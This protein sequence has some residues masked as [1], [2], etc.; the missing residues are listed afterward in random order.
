MS[1]NSD[2]IKKNN[3]IVNDLPEN[4][5][6]VQDIQKIKKRR[7]KVIRSCLFCRQR[8]LKCDHNYPKCSSCATRNIENCVYL[9]N[10]T[11]NTPSN[12]VEKNTAITTID[13]KMSIL[14]GKQNSSID[15]LTDD[16]NLMNEYDVYSITGAHG[17]SNKNVLLNPLQNYG[18]LFSKENKDV[19]LGP[20]SLKAGL[21][22][23]DIKFNTKQQKLWNIFEKER[24]QWKEANLRLIKKEMK[25]VER[26]Q[27]GS[28]LLEMCS[29]LPKYSE[30]E[31]CVREYFNSCYHSFFHI[32]D[33]RKVLKD[34]ESCI[35]HDEN[36]TVIE[37][38]LL[39]ERNYFSLAIVLYL[40]LFMHFQREAPDAMLQFFLALEAMSSGPLCFI[41]RAQFLMLRFLFKIFNEPYIHYLYVSSLVESLCSIIVVLGL[42]RD[43]RKI[44][45][46]KESK[47]GDIATLENLWYWTLYADYITS[48][49]LGKPLY[50]SDA[51][52]MPSDLKTF[53][54]GRLPLLKRFLY[55]S[56]KILNDLL[57]PTGIPALKVHL[58]II[59]KFMKKEFKR[60]RFYTDAKLV[61]QADL[62]EYL[63]LLPLMALR[64]CIGHFFKLLFGTSNTWNE[65]ELIRCSFN[66]LKMC[67]TLLTEAGSKEKVLSSQRSEF[68]FAKPLLNIAWAIRKCTVIRCYKDFFNNL[69]N[70]DGVFENCTK[71]SGKNN[72]L[73][74]LINSLD[75]FNA[76]ICY[77][78][79]NYIVAFQK[80]CEY[81]DE[82]Y[83]AE[84]KTISMSTN[85]TLQ[86]IQLKVIEKLSRSLLSE[87]ITE[88]TNFEASDQINTTSNETDD[89]VSNITGSL[90]AHS[91]E[92]TDSSPQHFQNN[93]NDQT[94]NDKQYLFSTNSDF[95]TLENLL[96]EDETGMFDILDLDLKQFLS[97]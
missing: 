31:T 32:L 71:D 82:Y 14:S 75:S 40:V 77:K 29:V 78:R 70:T 84:N 52:F 12:A 47:I 62:F 35:I 97:M 4:N 94:I 22:F 53:E 63:V 64:L 51:H 90:S 42:N 72:L 9:S 20:T 38:K 10:G 61:K 74:Q 92:I 80:Y 23:S 69:Y 3:I 46:G 15:N 60:I 56:R 6:N 26:S 65:N 55:I 83:D 96:G 8:K 7:R 50:F 79:S 76:K 89:S 95:L 21:V 33:E 2:S 36:D 34:M 5:D 85:T 48:F 11:N 68:I 19:Y 87:A 43:I 30:I 45:T 67:T 93:F 41:E 18:F 25:I 59:N 49:E 66:T 27:V 1:V 16:N 44:Y 24:L 39:E 88:N 73:D 54:R 17:V 81:L 57:K 28:L 86:S 58:Q 13:T 91:I 37:L